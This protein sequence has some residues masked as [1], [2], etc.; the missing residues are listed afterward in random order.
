[1]TREAFDAV[2]LCTG[3]D[4]DIAKWRSSLMGSLVDCGE[5]VRDPLGLGVGCTERG[6]AI[7]RAGRA[8]DRVLLIGPLRRGESWESTAVP[9]IGQQAAEVAAR[10]GSIGWGRSLHRHTRTYQGVAPMRI[11]RVV[12]SLV[13][14]VAFAG[15]AL[16][17]MSR[18]SMCRTTRRAKLYRE[19]NEAFAKHWKE[20]TGQTVTV[21][22]SHGGSG[23]RP[24][25]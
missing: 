19:F 4:P 5:V 18:C 8:S 22:M 14:A 23:V 6:E 16:A 13:G 10:G 3:P 21:Q 9:E 15:V 20:T 24:A 2:V 12:A 25:R 7:T 17:R 11:R 1:M